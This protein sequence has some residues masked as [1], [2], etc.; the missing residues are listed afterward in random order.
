[1]GPLGIIKTTDPANPV[2]MSSYYGPSNAASIQD[3]KVIGSIRRLLYAFFGR[4]SV[5]AIGRPMID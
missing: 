4:Q 3:V 5:N 1:M 2:F